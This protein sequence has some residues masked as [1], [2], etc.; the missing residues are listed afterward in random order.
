MPT[1]GPMSRARGGFSQIENSFLQDERLSGDAKLLGAVTASFANRDG[2]AW[3]GVRL[4]CK[5]TGMGAER[6]KKARSALVKHGALVLAQS[7]QAGRFGRVHYEV[8]GALL[9]K[10]EENRAK[11]GGQ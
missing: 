8:T 7:R 6:V 5:L 1:A 11:R 10:R 2:L 3:P 9:H 4:L